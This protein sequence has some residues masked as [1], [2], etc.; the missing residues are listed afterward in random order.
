MKEG[1]SKEAIQT[2]VGAKDG[3]GDLSG[4][5]AEMRGSQC[6]WKVLDWHSWG[7]DRQEFCQP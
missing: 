4:M 6:G 5:F 7:R 1:T 2:E 3:P